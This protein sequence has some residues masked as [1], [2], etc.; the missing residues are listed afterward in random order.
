MTRKRTSVVA[1]VQPYRYTS[2]DVPIA[3]IRRFARRIGARFHPQKI[4]LF[5][6]YAYG[7]PHGESDVDLLVIMPAR[8]VVQQAIRICLEF[9]RPFSFDLIVCSPAQ[10]ERG[11]REGDW[12]LRDVIERGKV[13]YEEAHGK[14]GSQGRGGLERGGRARRPKATVARPGGFHY[15]QAVEKLLKALLQELGTAVPR[16]HDLEVLLDLLLPHDASLASLRR[17]LTSLGR[18]AVEYR[19]PGLRAT[20]RRMQAAHRHA[21]RARSELRARLGLTP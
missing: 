12:F 21:A 18:Y 7:T 4:I 20:T 3:A 16:T 2:P 9:A 10:V 11:L 15:Q 13:L 14:M 17:H 19:Y 1:H 6:S 8:D 5:G